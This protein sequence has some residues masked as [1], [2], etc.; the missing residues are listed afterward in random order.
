M[1]LILVVMQLAPTVGILAGGYADT[2]AKD[3]AVFVATAIDAI[4]NHVHLMVAL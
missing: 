1:S 4:A 2:V 3:I